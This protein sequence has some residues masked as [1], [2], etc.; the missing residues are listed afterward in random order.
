MLKENNHNGWR[1]FHTPLFMGHCEMRLTNMMPPERSPFP[2]D[3]LIIRYTSL[4]TNPVARL[5]LL[6]AIGQ[7][8]SDN[9]VPLSELLSNIKLADELRV[10]LESQEASRFWQV[11]GDRV[12]VRLP[13]RKH[14]LV[15]TGQH[16]QDLHAYVNRPR[17]PKL[18][19]LNLI[20]QAA[21][22]IA[23]SLH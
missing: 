6:A 8:L 7:L 14:V 16:L 12:V 11:E 4:S 22:R 17:R 18:A 20:W 13:C 15:G 3:V 19:N 23:G 2:T 10:W 5:Q 1:G 9:Q 21:G